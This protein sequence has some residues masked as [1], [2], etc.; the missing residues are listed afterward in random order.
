MNV[1]NVLSS[2]E[3]IFSQNENLHDSRNNGNIIGYNIST[4]GGVI[5]K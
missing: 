3:Q 2:Y 1:M 5:E 4:L